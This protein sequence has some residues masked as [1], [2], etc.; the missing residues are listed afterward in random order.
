MAR[1]GK[2]GRG[3]TGSA[4]LSSFISGLVQQSVS[5]NERALVNAFQDQ[6]E[7]G[8]SV[9]TG[10]DI[11]AYV[12]SRL[13]GLDPN[14]AEYAYYVNLRETARRQERAK[15]VQSLT[16]SFN[17]SMGDNFNEFYD[18]ISSILRSG[19][20]SE[21]ERQEFQSV[22]TSKT[23]DYVELVGGQYKT[24]AVSYEELLE[25]TDSAIGL[26][27]GTVQ[28]NALVY[29]ADVIMDREAQSLSSGM[30]S[31][32]DYRTRVEAAFRGIDPE[33][34]TTFDLKNKMFTTIWNA[35]VDKEYGKVLAAQDKPTGKQI[36]KTQNYLEWARGKL[37]ELEDSGITGG[38]LYNSIKNN[39]R[40]YDNTLSELKE[41]A[42]SELYQSRLANT[43]SSKKVLDLFASQASLYVSG[44]AQKSLM[45]MEGGITLKNLLDA[46]PFAMV[47]YFDINP[48]AQDDFD[49]A[50]DE[51]RNNSKG[52]VATAKS[53]GASTGDAVALRNESV[54][55]ARS[56][57]QDTTLEDYEDAFDVK[58]E[59][60]GKANGDDS[61]IEGINSEWL[62]FLKG[63]N[64][65]SFGK[66]I[67]APTGGPVTA[68]IGNEIALYE[69]GG[70]GG[71]F[72][73]V[74]GTFLDL[75]IPQQKAD[76]TNPT[77]QPKTN[78]QIEA[79]NA[80]KTTQM[81]ALLKQGKAVR[82]IDGG[83]VGTTIGLRQAD[84]SKGEFAFAE[85]NANGKMTPVIR[86][87]I[88]VNGVLRGA[89]IGGA[90]W[91]H[92]FPDTKVWVAADGKTY[93]SPPIKMLNGGAPELDGNGNPVRITFALDPSIV[94]PNNEIIAGGAATPKERNSNAVEVDPAV[95]IT[96]TLNDLYTGAYRTSGPN[97]LVTPTVLDAVL[98]SY[99]DEDA[100]IKIK[101]QIAIYNE[102]VG[103]FDVGYGESRLTRET[104]GSLVNPTYEEKIGDFKKFIGEGST[105]GKNPM[106]ETI[107][108][109]NSDGKTRYTRVPYSSAYTETSPGVY[110]R[111]D[112]A[113]A[114]DAL[115]GKPRPESEQFFPKTIDV[116]K[117]LD[118][119]AVKPYIGKSSTPSTYPSPEQTA[120]DHFFRNNPVAINS[121]GD[122]SRAAANPVTYTPGP[123]IQPKANLFNSQPI[124]DFRAGERAS[125]S[126]PSM[127][128][129]SSPT[130]TG[131]NIQSPPINISSPEM[132][133][134]RAGERESAFTGIKAPTAPAPRVPA[135]P[136]GG[137]R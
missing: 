122:V 9:P 46:D 45:E 36:S 1:R 114:V 92:Y 82:F 7:Y 48:S 34:A 87:G 41:K 29:R 31:G 52:L 14:S 27:E 55:F 61:V 62:K 117:S 119:P 112:S 24:G 79:E 113:T 17:A 64:T 86:Q 130:F 134:F 22:L 49:A 21:A 97:S 74:G 110:V 30:L 101:E 136:R 111:K 106:V 26:L 128:S 80:A 38:E 98:Y 43:E 95:A 5:M 76:E 19:D 70:A 12:A 2:F 35:E 72:N 71:E 85:L 135:G 125:A 39:I 69:V 58:L 4:N 33:S 67:A 115:W 37:S 84:Q 88:P 126:T 65:S 100:K 116:S 47:R 105:D 28:E 63:E 78:S 90:E 53:I 99:D 20:L 129:T 104:S 73:A 50:L 68:L 42:G 123:P 96:N 16:D 121:Y 40:S 3:T 91:G 75:I 120:Q 118:L 6:T 57:N 81:S 8:G 133:A 10:A 23:A 44:A 109:R 54:A 89:E 32:S 11:D 107:I 15:R 132:V 51:F 83:G 124:I 18:E 66:G 137:A 25:K 60:I 108:T 93:T 103:R 77:Q 94:A 59:L 131:I 56:T 102:R 13:Q 127:T